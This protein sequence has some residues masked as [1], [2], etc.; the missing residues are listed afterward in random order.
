MKKLA[1]QPLQHM[2]KTIIEEDVPV[3]YQMNLVIL[4]TEDDIGFITSD[5]SCVRYHSRRRW[6]TLR[7]RAIEVSMPVSPNSL[8]LFCSEDLPN[9]MSINPVDLDCAYQLRRAGF[10]EYLV[11]RANAAKPVWFI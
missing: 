5:A 11:V 3:L 10:A 6:P 7:S 4:T 1:D 9:C 8:A 2:F